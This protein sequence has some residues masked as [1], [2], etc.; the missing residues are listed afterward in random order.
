MK[1]RGCRFNDCKIVK[2]QLLFVKKDGK[3]EVKS[4]QYFE[5]NMT[6][7][8]FNVDKERSLIEHIK[9]IILDF[10]IIVGRK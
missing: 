7:M 9:D 3:E 4:G 10:T 8:M 1:E 5:L 2:R 6:P